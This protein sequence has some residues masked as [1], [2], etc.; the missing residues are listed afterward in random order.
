MTAGPA[1]GRE[2]GLES[3]QEEERDEG[4]KVW[5]TGAVECVGDEVG[6]G[7]EWG[8]GFDG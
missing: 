1:R 3:A 5:E 8:V 6:Q 2:A 7:G 4:D